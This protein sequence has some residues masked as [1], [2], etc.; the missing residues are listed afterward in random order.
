MVRDRSGDG[1]LKAGSR[2][3]STCE[4]RQ[5]RKVAAVSGSWWV[6]RGCLA[7]ATGP[8]SD[9]AVRGQRRGPGDPPFHGGGGGGG[10]R[11]ALSAGAGGEG[12]RGDRGDGAWGAPAPG[13]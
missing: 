4:P 5:D 9:R 7:G 11:R 8:L 13:A 12:P 1:A 2:A 10:G 3:T 6:P